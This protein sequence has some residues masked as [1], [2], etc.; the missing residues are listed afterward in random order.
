MTMLSNRTCK[1]TF[2]AKPTARLVVATNNLPVIRDKSWGP[3]LLRT[4]LSLLDRKRG[5]GGWSLR[6]RVEWT[7]LSPRGGEAW[8]QMEL[9]TRQGVQTRLHLPLMSSELVFLT[10]TASAGRRDVAPVDLAPIPIQAD[11]VDHEATF[12]AG[13][14]LGWWG[15][16]TA[17]LAAGDF[18]FELGN[19]VEGELVTV[20]SHDRSLV[21]QVE[22][23]VLDRAYFPSSG[24]RL[25][26]RWRRGGTALGGDGAYDHL[27]ADGLAAFSA[28]H[29]TLTLAAVVS[30]GLGTEVPLERAP[31][32]GGF[33]GVVGAPRDAL[34]GGYAGMAKAGWSYRLGRPARDPGDGGIRFGVTAEAAQAWQT[35]DEVEVTRDALRFGGSVWVGAQTPL[36]PLRVAWARLDGVRNG[37][38]IQVGVDP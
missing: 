10:A 19:L 27:M 23:D 5:A 36:G 25:A 31:A 7:R 33:D 2:T 30:T 34:W 12:G 37:W 32:L 17:A 8:L 18:D 24:H 9:G 38:I 3:V 6:S 35:L 22:G 20:R 14:R 11:L 26:V 21:V 16:A 13:V 1:P 4:G 15:E 28:G 29:H